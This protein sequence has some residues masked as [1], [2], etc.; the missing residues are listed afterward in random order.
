MSE[1][2]NSILVAEDNTVLRDVLRFNL[3]RAGFDVTVAENGRVA[4][5]YLEARAFDLLITD[6]QMPELDGEGLCRVA[7]EQLALS[8]LPILM[9]SAKG[10]ELDTEML[11]ERY[12]VSKVLY[13]PFSMKEIVALAQ[14]LIASPALTPTP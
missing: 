3:Q 13:K 6:Y 14:E 4:A 12:Q 8:E 10:L 1:Q 11:R 5:D 7:R 9:C 2:N